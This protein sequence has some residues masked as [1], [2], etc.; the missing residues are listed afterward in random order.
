MKKLL[1]LLLLLVPVAAS[2][3]AEF[4]FSK[5]LAMSDADFQKAGFKFKANR[6]QYILKE[7]TPYALSLFFTMISGVSDNTP[8]ADEYNIEVQYGLEGISSIKINFYNDDTYHDILEFA[9]ENGENYIETNSGNMVRSRYDYD[10]CSF[11][12]TRSI[13]EGTRTENQWD[14][15][16]VYTNT[17]NRYDYIISTGI[18]PWSNWHKRQEAREQ[19]REKRNARKERVSDF[20]YME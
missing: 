17:Y 8:G 2:P 6:N 18:E 20:M 19:R 7:S 11:T 9:T 1:L 10:G 16:L 14:T 4:P 13:Q 12:L 5:M 3:Q 15:P